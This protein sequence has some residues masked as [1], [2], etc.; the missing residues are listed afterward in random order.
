MPHEGVIAICMLPLDKV[1]SGTLLTLG[2]L[3]RL[4]FPSVTT[5]ASGLRHSGAI[6][7]AGERVRS[8]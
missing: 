6:G 3:A 2:V 1:R 7:R 8:T 4:A 5:K